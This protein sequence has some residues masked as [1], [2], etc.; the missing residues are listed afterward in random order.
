MVFPKTHVVL[1]NS[2]YEKQVFC[3]DF[4]EVR[5]V[6]LLPEGIDPDEAR[7]I[8]H[9]PVEP[10]R[11]LYVGVLKRYKNVNKIIEGFAHLMRNG[12]RNF[13]LVLVGD[14]P[15][16]NS[17]VNLAHE[18]GISG[19]VEWKC[20]LSRQQLLSEY[21]EASVF[22]QLSPLESFSRVVYDALLI[23]VPVVV[24]NFGALRHLVA[25]GFAEGVS[26]LT[27][28]EIADALLKATKNTYARISLNTNTFLDWKTYSSRI[29]DIYEK[30]QET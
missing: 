8:K 7:K 15:E 13:R 12:D 9:E 5:N 11:I 23:G 3:E 29:I 1:V 22:L 10:K 20:R 6:I 19:F 2:V 16:R 17:L 27:K 14:G 4:P 25:S 26:S 24:L 30:L 28:E 21:S 18:L